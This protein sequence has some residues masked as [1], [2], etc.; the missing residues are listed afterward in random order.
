MSSTITRSHAE[1]CVGAAGWQHGWL[2]TSLPKLWL[3]LHGLLAYNDNDVADDKRGRGW[4]KESWHPTIKS[5]VKD[6]PIN[7]MSTCSW[8]ALTP[9][10]DYLRAHWREFLHA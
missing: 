6:Y 3:V 1:D 8:M 9:Y 10:C 5:Q 4:G 7:D 2:K